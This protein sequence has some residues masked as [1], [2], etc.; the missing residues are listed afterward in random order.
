MWYVLVALMSRIS[1]FCC[2]NCGCWVTISDYDHK[3]YSSSSQGV[4]L[5]KDPSSRRVASACTTSS[6]FSSRFC[7]R[8]TIRRLAHRT[9]S[10]I[11]DMNKKSKA[12]KE[13]IGSCLKAVLIVNLSFCTSSRMLLIK[14]LIVEWYMESI[15]LFIVWSDHGI[16]RMNSYWSVVDDLIKI[17]RSIQVDE[18]SEMSEQVIVCSQG[19]RYFIFHTCTIDTGLFT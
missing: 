3:R 9:T 13:N 19:K 14:F 12:Y 4:Y 11:N 2:D 5:E 17:L 16:V 18:D 8:F 7:R 1:L 6:T 15:C 10:K